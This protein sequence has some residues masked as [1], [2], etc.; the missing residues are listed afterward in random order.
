M[1]ARKAAWRFDQGK[2]CGPEAN[3]AKYL[4]GEAAWAAGE[5]CMQTHG[6]FA[7]A[8]EYDLER[9][10]REA[11]LYRIAPISPNLILAYPAQRVLGLPRLLTVVHVA[12]SRKTPG[13]TRSGPKQSIGSHDMRLRHLLLALGVAGLVTVAADRAHAQA[14]GNIVETA[15]AAGQFQTLLAAAEAAGLVE[16][17]SGPG[18]LTVFAPTDDAFARLPAGTVENLLRPENRDQLT[19]ILSFHVVPGVITSD[20]LAGIATRLET[21]AGRDLAIDATGTPVNVGGATL[22]AAD[23]QATNGVIHVVDRVILPP[24]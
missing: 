13:C 11:R 12:V 2:P 24:M 8:R 17:L 9:K 15:A 20:D 5:A 14:A 16:T 4:T 18:P 23:I 19:T 3:M 21:A 6:G 1:M 22:A 10:W 7:F